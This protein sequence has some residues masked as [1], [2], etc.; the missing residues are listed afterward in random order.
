VL[1]ARASESALS[2]LSLLSAGTLDELD[3]LEIVLAGIGGVALLL[4]G[5]LAEEAAAARGRLHIDTMGFDPAVVRF[6]V[7]VVG[8]GHVLV[9]S[10]WP[11]IDRDAS[12]DRVTE[13]LDAI[14]ATG[15]DRERIA[16]GNALGLLGLTPALRTP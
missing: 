15:E 3:G 7:D 1:L 8:P 13:L 12:R 16:G 6:F 4:G 14:G 2:T 5:F 11:I 9:G 10:D